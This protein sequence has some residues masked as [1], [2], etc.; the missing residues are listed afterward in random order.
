M[1]ILVV[2]KYDIVGKKCDIGRKKC[3][4]IINNPCFI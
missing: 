2:K 4:I 1:V 3:V